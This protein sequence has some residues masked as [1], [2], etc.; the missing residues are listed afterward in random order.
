MSAPPRHPVH[1]EWYEVAQGLLAGTLRDL[2]SRFE[3]MQNRADPNRSWAYNCQSACAEIAVA[4][5]LGLYWGATVRL[6]RDPHV[7]D[8]GRLEVRY[9]PL[10]DGELALHPADFA[11]TPYVHVTGRVPNLM[12]RGWVLAREGRACGRQYDKFSNG[13]PAC[14]VP[15]ESLH[16]MTDLDE[17]GGAPP[18]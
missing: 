4:K 6:R 15:L 8:V 16:P 13:R 18:P 7:H 1:L 14:W 9:T 11:D 5:L 3:G 17:W 12:V 2:V 10:D